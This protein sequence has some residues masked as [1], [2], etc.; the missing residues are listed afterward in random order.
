MREAVLLREREIAL[1]VRRHAHHGAVAVGHQHVV[2]DPDVD[3]LAGERMRDDE[4]GRHPLLLHRR[5]VGFHHAA[6]PAFVDERGEL[7]IRLRRMRRERMLGGDRAERDAHDRVDARR[8]DVHLAVADQRAVVAADV[9]RKGEAHADALAD[10]VRL[11]RLHAVG[12]ARH[13]VEIREELLRVVGDAQEIHR[14]LALLHRRAGAPAASVDHLLVGEHGLVDRIPVHDA[15]SSCTRCPF[16]ASS[17][18]TT[19]SSDST[20]DR[21]CEISRDQ[22][23]AQP[24][25]WHCVFM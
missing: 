3:L 24:I 1:V 9:V 22:S 5:E 18:R 12:P 6:A 21:R 2:A 11:H 19:G 13:P 14:D 8:E 16:R 25:A 10:P 23:S 7:R 17:G 4:P 15:A 20:R